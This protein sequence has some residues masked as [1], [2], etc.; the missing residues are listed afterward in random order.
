[1]KANKKLENEN[2]ERL[3]E[4][5]FT[6]CAMHPSASEADLDRLIGE[7][8]GRAS[9]RA[10]GTRQRGKAL[11]FNSLGQVIH[12]WKRSPKYLTNDGEPMP[13]APRGRAPSIESLFRDVR[14]SEYFEAGL[15]HLK[16]MRHV[17]KT[18]EGLYLP[19]ELTII[20]PTLTPELF[21]VLAQTI[22]RLVATVMYN[23]S[24]RGRKTDRLIERM[25]FVPDLPRQQIPAFKRFVRQQ[26]VVFIDTLDDWLESRRSSLSK[27]LRNR[28]P[29]AAGCHL[30]GFLEG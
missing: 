8:R 28:R 17:S 12:R 18:K 3:L 27:G 2:L 4:A 30:F 11:D 25:T 13:L 7:A 14:R 22:R 15:R 1:M 9:R 23:T 6:I 26:G 20:V 16:K 10:A 29:V 24:Y 21:D 19:R 5:V